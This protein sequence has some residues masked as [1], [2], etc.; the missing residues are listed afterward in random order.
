ML[1][2]ILFED[3]HISTQVGGGEAYNQ[4]ILGLQVHGPMTG[5][6]LISRE[7]GGGLKAVWYANFVYAQYFLQVHSHSS[8]EKLTSKL[9]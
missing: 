9:I 4:C 3:T 1:I 6:G 2:K 5:G 8:I 7:G